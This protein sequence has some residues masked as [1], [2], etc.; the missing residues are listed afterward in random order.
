MPLSTK[1]HEYITMSSKA[2]QNQQQQ[3]NTL[4]RETRTTSEEVQIRIQGNE[5]IIQNQTYNMEKKQ[6]TSPHIAAA[7]LSYVNFMYELY[8]PYMMK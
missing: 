1:H 5:V 2:S 7:N 3:H 4:P 8:H 6:T